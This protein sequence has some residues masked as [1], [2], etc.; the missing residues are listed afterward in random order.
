MDLRI[1]GV[2]AE[3]AAGNAEGHRLNQNVQSSEGSTVMSVCQPRLYRLAGA[4][5]SESSNPNATCM[6][7]EIYVRD[8]C[9]FGEYGHRNCFYQ[10]HKKQ[11]QTKRQDQNPAEQKVD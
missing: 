11:A 9:R 10:R 4:I 5:V 6:Q 1:D 8:H 3:R 2:A 7:C